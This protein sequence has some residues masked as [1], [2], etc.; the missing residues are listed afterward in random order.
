MLSTLLA[1]LRPKARPT[2]P[3][4]PNNLQPGQIV[5]DYC[6]GQ[7]W[8]WH[9]GGPA[10]TCHRCEYGVT[11]PGRRATAIEWERHCYTAPKQV[12]DGIMV[13]YRTAR[14]EPIK[15]PPR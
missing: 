2:L 9:S 15:G 7:G 1:L 13:R 14:A 10:V 6:K 3:P 8:Y 11:T 4:D 12:L 5:C